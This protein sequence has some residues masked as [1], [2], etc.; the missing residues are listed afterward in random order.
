MIRSL[1]IT[2]IFLSLLGGYIEPSAFSN[3][4]DRSVSAVENYWYCKK[5]L[6]VFRSNK[7][8]C[9]H[10]GRNDCFPAS[11]NPKVKVFI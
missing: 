5:C 1:G 8:V 3:H 2:V 11:V 10:C 4:P 6:K 7:N 9:P